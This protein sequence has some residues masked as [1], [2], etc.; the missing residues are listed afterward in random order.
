MTSTSVRRAPLASS[1][2]ARLVLVL[3]AVALPVTGCGSSEGEAPIANP[4]APKAT[5]KAAAKLAPAA[6]VKQVT[7]RNSDF[8]GGLK[9]KLT[10][11]G[12]KVAGQITLNNCGDDFSTEAHRVARRQITLVSA[13]GEAS[14]VSNEVAAYDRP[15]QAAKALKQY[16]KSVVGCRKNV[17]HKMKEPGVP[18]LRYEVNTLTKATGLPIKDNAVVT[19]RLAA[20][21][22]KQRLHLVLIL[23]RHDAVLT[24]VYLQSVTKPT[25]ADVASLHT[26]AVITGK[27]LAAS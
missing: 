23:Q 25:D 9:L 2:M 13:K 22:V 12:D 24:A 15:A 8:K 10:P 3:L 14:G 6:L 7:L 27:R 16:R 26:L 11:G 19:Q 20:K 4:G 21:G 17:Y 5:G 1:A 18:D